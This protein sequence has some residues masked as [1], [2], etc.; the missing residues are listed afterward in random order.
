MRK[1]KEQFKFLWGQG[2]GNAVCLDSMLG[3]VN[4]QASVFNLFAHKGAR[5]FQQILHVSNNHGIA[6]RLVQKSVD[7]AV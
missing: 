1:I 2:H 4:V 7:A 5:S 3:L 6:D